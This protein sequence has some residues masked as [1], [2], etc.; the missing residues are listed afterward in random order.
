MRIRVPDECVTMLSQ[1][2]TRHCVGDVLHHA[3][4]KPHPPNLHRHCF[5]HLHKTVIIEMF[6]GHVTSLSQSQSLSCVPGAQGKAS[7]NENHVPGAQGGTNSKAII[8]V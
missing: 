4:N 1:L 7:S 3:V 5:V 2:P 8:K 6:D